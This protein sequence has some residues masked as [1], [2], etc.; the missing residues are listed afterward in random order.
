MNPDDASRCAEEFG[1]A[2]LSVVGGF[3]NGGSGDPA[4]GT[5]GGVE[6]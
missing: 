4:D 6:C 1:I 3:I 2:S 5:D